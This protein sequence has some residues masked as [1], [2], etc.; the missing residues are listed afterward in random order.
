MH[1]LLLFDADQR[2]IPVDALQRIFRSVSGF[3][4]VRC[5]TPTGT[6]IEADYV[7]G[8]DF[9][10]VRLNATCEAISVRGT[11]GAALS[12][13][14]ILHRNLDIP[15]RMVDT[16]YSFD[17]KLA[18]FTNLEQLEAAIDKARSS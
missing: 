2:T 16:E 10:T 11:S 4:K 7:E 3:Q 18:D 13:A 9:T 14:W 17:L 1:N 15:L 5:N 8:Q 12:A 6:P